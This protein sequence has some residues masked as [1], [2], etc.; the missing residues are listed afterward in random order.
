MFIVGQCATSV[1][2]EDIEQ[3]REK[4]LVQTSLIVVGTADDHLRI[5]S[6]K[7]IVD[8]ITQSIVDRCILEEM[9]NFIGGILLQPHPLP[10][11]H[12]G[13][14]SYDVSKP[15]KK[16]SRKRKNS[17]SSSVDSNDNGKKSR[18]V[19]PILA[20]N[21]SGIPGIN[22]G[23]PKQSAILSGGASRNGHLGVKRPA[24]S[25]S[26]VKGNQSGSVPRGTHSGSTGTNGGLTL[27]IGG[28]ASLG[29]VGPIRLNPSGE[30]VAKGVTRAPMALGL[31]QIRKSHETKGTY[32]GEGSE[33]LA[34]IVPN[35]GRRISSAPDRDA[36]AIF[37]APDSSS[38]AMTGRVIL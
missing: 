10:L 4:M 20:G 12:V 26:S 13:Q 17:T 30:G 24:K 8:G 32:S 3:I 31:T 27:N 11:R 2:P 38:T 35:P 6:R 37:A 1:R 14:F 19:T 16:E 18:P 7:K 25:R 9:G 15:H 33:D 22:R 28:M 29:P 23:F 5:S 34:G 36:S 21:S